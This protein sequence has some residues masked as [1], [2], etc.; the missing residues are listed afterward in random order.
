MKNDLATFLED[1]TIL[2]KIDHI[3]TAAVKNI[4]RSCKTFIDVHGVLFLQKNEQ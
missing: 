2:V 3:A 1:V 4:T